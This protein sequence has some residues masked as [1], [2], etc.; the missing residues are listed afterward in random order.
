MAVYQTSQIMAV[1]QTAVWLGGMICVGLANADHP[2]S[3]PAKKTKCS[4]CLKAGHDVSSCWT[5]N[6]QLAPGGAP[7]AG[8]GRGGA[9]T[10]TRH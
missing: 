6:P 3:S 8:N 5:K 10:N 1:S 4:Y 7:P 9:S 2:G